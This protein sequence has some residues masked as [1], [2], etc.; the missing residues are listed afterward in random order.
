MSF[1]IQNNIEI[2]LNDNNNNNNFKYFKVDA[3]G[4]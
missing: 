2:K 3:C 1:P 4:R